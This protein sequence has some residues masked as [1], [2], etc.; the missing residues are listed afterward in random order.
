MDTKQ[1]PFSIS[2]TL[3]RGIV[4][5]TRPLHDEYIRLALQMAGI[6]TLSIGALAIA[7]TSF[8]I[9]AINAWHA[10]AI[11]LSAVIIIALIGAVTIIS[12]GRRAYEALDWYRVQSQANQE[13]NRQVALVRAETEVNIYGGRNKV[14]VGDS[15]TTNNTLA[16]ETNS[17]QAREEFVRHY[18]EFIERARLMQQVQDGKT[19]FEARHFLKNVPNGKS[20]W[21]FRDGKT[22]TRGEYDQIVEFAA[23]NG[24]APS[25][26]R[27]GAA[28]QKPLLE[29]KITHIE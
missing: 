7:L 17:S 12:I 15:Q 22:I 20:D 9:A 29:G 6:L 26:R 11:A 8:V 23:T 1:N 5:P 19:G 25:E 4:T 27:R 13:T 16:I 3:T 2:D 18:C 10:L 24:I 21:V 14:I 28:G